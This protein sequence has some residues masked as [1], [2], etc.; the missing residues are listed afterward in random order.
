MENKGFLYK[1]GKGMYKGRKF[2]IAFWIIALLISLYF[3][4]FV[5]DAFPDSGLYAEGSE[6]DQGTQIIQNDLDAAK[7]TLHIAVVGEEALQRDEIL[8][9]FEDDVQNID[10]VEGVAPFKA[11][12]NNEDSHKAAFELDL[13]I[14]EKESL[15]LFDDLKET[16]TAP[17]GTE[18]FIS[19]YPALL[20]D[21]SSATIAGIAKAE[22]IGLPIAFIVLLLVFGTIFAGML[23][24]VVGAISIIVTLAVAYLLTMFNDYS[25]FMPTIVAM[26]GMALGIDYALF[27]ISRFREELKKGLSIQE[28]VANTSQ[29]AGKSVLFSGVAV[30]VGLLGMLFIKLNVFMSIAIGGS[31]VVGMSV[32]VCLTMLLALLGVLGDRINRWHVIPKRFRN[33]SE[34]L[35]WEKIAR[36]VMKRPVIHVLLIGGLLIV[37]MLPITGMK[38][39]EPGA[40]ILP[41]KYDSRQGYDIIVDAYDERSVSPVMVAIEMDEAYYE[42]SSIDAMT[43]FTEDVKGL[44]NV[45]SV[46]SY[47]SVVEE[48]GEL[49]TKEMVALDEVRDALEEEQ[50][51]SDQTAIVIVEPTIYPLDEKTNDI[52][53]EIRGLEHDGLTTYVFGETAMNVDMIERIAE[54]VPYTIGFVFLMTFIILLVA[55]RS[56]VLPLKAIVMNVLSLGASFGIVVMIVQHGYLAEFFGIAHLGFLTAVTPVVIFCVVFGISM[57]YEVFMLSRIQEEYKRTKDNEHSTAVGLMRTGNIITSA[58]LILIIVVGAFIFTDVEIIKALGLGLA[59]AVF[60]DATIVRLF[61]VPSFMKLMGDWNWWAPKWMFKK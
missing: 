12:V 16:I 11:E 56:V 22:K 30:L 40:E 52:I 44:E 42:E 55:F 26:L 29:M 7:T 21:F 31:I 35:M 19:G 27:M 53:H 33:R 8:S 20:D 23:P 18:I 43:A 49:D 3:V 1:W 2:V 45:S 58:A 24:I 10:Y 6:S 47:V 9:H 25:N 61:L 39:S 28:A 15:E 36:F 48:L 46:D 41:T 17:K 51:V 57:D 60:L 37:T 13:S 14:E 50:L 38:I 4:Q 59:I 54:G 5:M 34:G 32:I